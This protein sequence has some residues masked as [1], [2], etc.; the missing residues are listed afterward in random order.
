MIDRLKKPVKLQDGGIGRLP[1]PPS[2]PNVPAVYNRE[3]LFSVKGLQQ[4]YAGLPGAVKTPLR[5][6]GR[7]GAFLAGGR[8]APVIGGVAIGQGFDALARATNTPEEYEAMKEKARIQG[9]TGY[10]DDVNISQDAPIRESSPLEKDFP[11]MSTSEIIEFVNNRAQETGLDIAPSEIGPVTEQAIA[12]D[13]I[14]EINS[15]P[16]NNSS[17]NNNLPVDTG[18]AIELTDE[19]IDN[20]FRNREQQKIKADQ[21]YHYDYLPKAIEDGK[22]DLALQLDESVK[23]IMG[24]ESKR[25]KNLLLLQ[26]AS[27]LIS[28]RTDQ[29]GFKGF[30]DVL[31]QAGQQVIPAALALEQDRREDEIELKKAL[32]ANMGKK[33]NREKFGAKEKLVTF[34]LPGTNKQVTTIARMGDN[35]T[36]LA[37]L[38]DMDGDN[39]REIDITNLRYTMLDAPDAKLI[40]EYNNKIS[41]KVA[42]LA[43]TQEALKVTRNDPDLIASKGTVMEKLRIAGDVIRQWTGDQP[44]EKIIKRLDGDERNFRFQQKQALDKGDITEEEYN[45]QMREGSALFKA[46]KDELIKSLDQSSDLQKQAKLRTIELL[47]SYALAN[48][49]KNE[50]RLAVQDI[51]RAE[52]ATKQFGFFSSPEHVIARYVALE[53]QLIQSIQGDIK[54]ARVLG[55]LPE[56]IVDYDKA[57]TA[58]EMEREAEEEKFKVNLRNMFGYEGDAQNMYDKMTGVLFPAG[59]FGVIE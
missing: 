18:T 39:N 7:T 27:S 23:D 44:F 8:F 34:T 5:F 48:L 58:S 50:D 17:T 47:T 11:G 14:E 22:T 53:K 2:S 51:K 46:Q 1:M 20:E 41:Q 40:D 59:G 42:A 35:G 38:D 57:F 16:P 19:E 21:F 6:L 32:L 45:Q 56:Q 4:R 25:N 12:N 52:Q 54:K 15:D 26:L 9:G 28:G 24:E 36:V 37:T 31:G 13:Q 3:P 29:P 33:E 43:G 30:L 55:I 49:L 10:F